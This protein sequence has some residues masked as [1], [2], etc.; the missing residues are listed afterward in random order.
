MFNSSLLLGFLCYYV[1]LVL[2]GEL[3]FLERCY[4]YIGGEL[5]GELSLLLR[6]LL[7]IGLGGNVVYVINI[8]VSY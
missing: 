4:S 8:G 5:L 1:G 6:L 2:L 3:L 7:G